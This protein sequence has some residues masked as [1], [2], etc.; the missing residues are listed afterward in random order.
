[1]HRN[2]SQ[3]IADLLWEITEGDNNIKNT[4]DFSHY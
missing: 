2:L 4:K 1:M 3:F